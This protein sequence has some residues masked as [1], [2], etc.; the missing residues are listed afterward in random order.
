MNPNEFCSDNFTVKAERNLMKKE[1]ISR[2]K[3][4][5]A[6]LKVSFRKSSS[7]TALS[8]L[9][10]ELG[11]KK[12]SLYNYYENR[13]AMVSDVFRFCS[14]SLKEISLSDSQDICDF[15]VDLFRVFDIQMNTEI[16]SLIDSEKL[17]DDLAFTAFEE[18]KIRLIKLLRHRLKD[19]TEF[20]VGA[21]LFL[22]VD[23][24]SAKKMMARNGDEI[25]FSESRIRLVINS[26]YLSTET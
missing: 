2:E 6:F 20:F 21:L 4:I 18:F 22:L 15:S 1:K 19:R 3:I 13:D 17:F 11:I 12:A 5:E 14:D 8:D 7:G 26:F 24:V 10:N 9:A 25:E 16:L 23:Y